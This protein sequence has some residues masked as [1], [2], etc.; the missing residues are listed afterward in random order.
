MPTFLRAIL[1]RT[2]RQTN[3]VLGLSSGC[4]SRPVHARLQVSACSSYYF[5]HPG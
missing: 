3:L 1:T 2:V 4:T 5:C